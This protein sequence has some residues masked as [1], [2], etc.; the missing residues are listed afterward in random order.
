MHLLD[1]G[2]KLLAL[3]S[4]CWNAASLPA[5]GVTFFMSATARRAAAAVFAQPAGATVK[6]AQPVDR[7]VRANADRVR[8]C[9]ELLLCRPVRGRGARRVDFDPPQAATTSG[10]S[11]ERKST[12]HEGRR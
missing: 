2:R 9:D 5:E 10:T 3:G 7:A 6:P 8:R 1:A 12:A 11:E 4:N